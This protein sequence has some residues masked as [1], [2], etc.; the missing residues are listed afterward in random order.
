MDLVALKSE[1]TNGHPGTGPYSSDNETAANQLNV[2]NRTRSKATLRGSD[3]YNALVPAEFTA[4]QA[5]QQAR[6][7]DIFHLGDSI[8]VGPDSNVRS[9]LLSVFNGGSQ[10]RAN[11]IAAATEPASRANELGL[12]F[13][14]PSDV[15]DAR[16]LP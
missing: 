4:L 16:R 2:V 13:V 11:L 10:T 12:G 15:A 9:V 1:L 7:R 8:D 5:A 6:V 3:I 14:T